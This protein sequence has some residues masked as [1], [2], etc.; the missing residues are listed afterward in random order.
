MADSWNI[1]KIAR[2]SSRDEDQLTDLLAWL[3]RAEPEVVAALLTS[4]DCDASTASVATQRRVPD[5]RID[6]ELT[7]EGQ[8]AVV[9]E[10]NLG[11]HTTHLQC[12]TYIEYLAALPVDDRVLV[13]VTQLHEDWPPGIVDFAADHEVRLA[14]RRWWD[15]TLALEESDA[16]LALDFVE[17]LRAE[18]LVVPDA[19]TD[20]DWTSGAGIPTAAHAL[21]LEV[22]PGLAELSAIPS[23]QAVY[24][25]AGRY[26]S[27]YCSARSENAE[28]ALGVAATWRDLVDQRRITPKVTTPAIEGS[29]ITC[30]VRDL[31]SADLLADATKAVQA[32]GDGVVG[33]S[34]KQ[35]PV[36][37]TSAASVLTS[38]D[39]RVQVEQALGYARETADH[40]RRIGYLKDKPC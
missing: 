11:S 13:L 25:S 6:L 40:F 39:F 17:M 5:G 12:K 32:G 8:A 1:F 38:H 2:K 27:I 31:G 36:R 4:L 7:A 19:L 15:I 23:T 20:E 26:R 3:L 21:M 9:I 34:W 22:K 28:I 29:V 35:C 33:I 37:A 14:R 18:G 10:S 30:F 24:D 16:G